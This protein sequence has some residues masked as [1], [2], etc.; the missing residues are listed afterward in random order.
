MLANG[1]SGSGQNSSPSGASCT[2]GNG[3]PSG[4][5][6]RNWVMQWDSSLV[7]SRNGTPV[8]GNFKVVGMQDCTS[9]GCMLTSFTTA[10]PVLQDF[11]QMPINAWAD[12]LGNL[13]IPL[14]AGS[15]MQTAGANF[16]ADSDPVYY[17][18][19]ST[20][21]PSIGNAIPALYCLS[22]CPTHASLAT[23]A[24]DTSP[25]ML[26]PFA[27]STNQ[28][29]GNGSNEVTYSFGTNGLIDSTSSAVVPT[30]VISNPM[31]QG[32]VN[33]GRMFTTDLG[34]NCPNGVTYCEPPSPTVYY[35]YQTGT[36]Q[37]N[38]TMWLTTAS[39]SPVSFDPPQAASYTVPSGGAYGTWAGKAIQLQFNGFGNLS[40]IPGNCVDPQ[41]NAE[42]SC[43]PSTRF[44]PAF[45]LADGATLTIGGQQV[46][47]RALD[48]ELRL[49]KQSTCTLHTGT[50]PSLPTTVPH[51]PTDQ[52]DTTYYIGSSPTVGGSPAVVDGVLQ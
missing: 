23:A 14:P 20:V 26:S 38:Q 22:N 37:W 18:S 52:N 28:Q 4:S 8:T 12:T 47:T 34:T 39:G 41:T 33:S 50:A 9:N 42:T 49:A 30:G 17:Y 13:T 51:D 36:N 3:F 27:A 43:T 24:A 19:Q 10:T 11:K 32:G 16:H 5:D 29:W 1:V 44:V 45:A 15:S 35:T 40:G 46:V 48:S 2:G 6:F 7:V 25:F 21:L 31:W